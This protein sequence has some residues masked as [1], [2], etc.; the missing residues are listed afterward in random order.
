MAGNRQVPR[1]VP[2]ATDSAE[3][4]AFGRWRVSNPET[5]FDSQL[6]YDKQPLLWDEWGTGTGTHLPNESAVLMSVTSGQSLYRQTF[7]YHRYQPGKSQF[8]LCTGVM[9][10]CDE[11][12]IVKRSKVSGTVVETRVRWYAS[13][14]SCEF[15][16]SKIP[17]FDPSKSQ[18]F[19][20][21]MEWLGVGRVRTGFVIDGMPVVAHEWLHANNESTTYMTTANLPVRYEIVSD[22]SETTKRFGYFDDDNGFF[23]EAVCSSATGTMRHLCTTVISEG[24]QSSEQAFIF[25]ADTT[26]TAKTVSTTEIPIIAIRPKATFNSIVNRGRI[27][28]LHVHIGCTT[29][30]ICFRV[31]YNGTLTGASFTSANA[32]SIVE[33][34]T[35]ATT[36][37]DGVK[38]DADFVLG[39]K[40]SGQSSSSELF[41]K[42]PLT[43]DHAGA[44]PKNF[45]VTAQRVGNSDATVVAS[46]QWREI[47]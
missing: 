41:A 30:D 45:V 39:G 23:F 11:V 8:I 19:F 17:Y 46:I 21:D 40:Q 7:A 13:T 16:E 15:N 35:S 28:P 44:N 9:G 18:I 4:D 32:N 26:T 10:D 29:N 31:Y 5:I 33:Y 6:Q 38:I 20:V 2:G 42:Y 12:Y 47:R 37:T 27:E 3:S 14:A 36:Y 43:I 1:V 25:A 22:G 34:D 24:G